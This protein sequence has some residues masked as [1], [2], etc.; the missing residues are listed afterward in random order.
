MIDARQTSLIYNNKLKL[1]RKFIYLIL[2]SNFYYQM[3]QTQQL[4]DPSYPKQ[5]AIQIL[6]WI[7]WIVIFV[8]VL[9]SK[10]HE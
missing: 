8:L 1:A 6:N 9:I 2:V 3:L 10:K 7:L 5:R 4:F